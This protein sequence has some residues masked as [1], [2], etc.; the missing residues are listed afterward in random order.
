MIQNNLSPL[1]WYD[2]ISR[3]NHRKSYVQKV[4]PLIT[5][6][7][8]ILPFHLSR[9]TRAAEISYVR[10]WQLDGTYT[11]ITQAMKDSGLRVEKYEAQGFDV[12]YYTG[13]VP[14]SASFKQGSF[15]L[16][17]SDGTETWYSEVFNITPF[18]DDALTVEWWDDEP[19]LYTGSLIPYGQYRNKIYLCAELSRP[20][21]EYEESGETRDGF[22][23]PD[24][25]V[26]EKIYKFVVPAPEFLCDAMRTIKLSDHIIIKSK[27][28][29]YNCDTFLM[30][31][32]WNDNA[33][34]ASV[35]CEFKVDTVIKKIGLSAAMNRLG[36]SFDKSYSTD[37]DIENKQYGNIRTTKKCYQG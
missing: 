28:G 20:E 14:A 15:Y 30:T 2:D 26:S 23:F 35:E 22:F 33:D 6:M 25:I 17:M 3:Q 8:Y 9:K 4:Y 24:K 29:E 10:L 18:Y 27:G 31:P 34:L 1:P 37:F 19:L 13:K 12:I 5:P 16:S 11:D 21:Y 32:K 7:G 36:G